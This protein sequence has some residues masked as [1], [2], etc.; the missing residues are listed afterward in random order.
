MAHD[1][2]TPPRAGL[3]LDE[4]DGPVPMRVRI[5]VVAIIMAAVMTFAFKAGAAFGLLRSPG[6][7]PGTPS[8]ILPAVL[9]LLLLCVLAWKIFVGRDWARWIFAAIVLLGMAGIA[10]IFYAPDTLAI[11]VPQPMRAGTVIQFA[12]NCFA[13]VLLFTSDARQWFQR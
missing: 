5:A 2:F 13:L 10:M 12:L 6:M 4:D 11:S 3:E 8:D 1:P 9:V 7:R